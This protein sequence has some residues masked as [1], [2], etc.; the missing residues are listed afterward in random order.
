MG[1]NKPNELTNKSS[2]NKP[3]MKLPL[4]PQKS[5]SA[6][7]GDE[8]PGRDAVSSAPDVSPWNLSKETSADL[9]EQLH[10]PGPSEHRSS[11]TDRSCTCTPQPQALL[12]VTLCLCDTGGVAYASPRGLGAV[13]GHWHHS[14]RAEHALTMADARPD[15]SPWRAGFGKTQEKATPGW[16][17]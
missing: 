5:P 11:T 12:V 2:R 9:S 1:Q 17:S 10:W 3:I 6:S 16:G 7:L 8:G 14:L 13:P 15:S 4:L